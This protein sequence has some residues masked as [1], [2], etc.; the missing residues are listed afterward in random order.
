MI[1]LERRAEGKESK[2]SGRAG[3]EEAG[4][5]EE[6]EVIVSKS[7]CRKEG[8]VVWFCLCREEF[9]ARNGYTSQNC[10]LESSSDEEE[11]EGEGEG[12]G[13]EEEE[14]ERHINYV[15][16]D[17]TQPQNTGSSDAIIIH[18]VGE[19]NQVHKRVSR[20]TYMVHGMWACI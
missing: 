16:G 19:F 9:W 12:E 20:T 3:A 2:A 8:G 4:R 13:E 1:A 6:E 7:V 15:V 14:E 10:P 17:A 18:C 11:R 5:E